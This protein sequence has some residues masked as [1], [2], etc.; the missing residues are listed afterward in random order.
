M[1]LLLGAPTALGRDSSS[2]AKKYYPYPFSLELDVD[3]HRVGALYQEIIDLISDGEKIPDSAFDAASYEFQAS[4]DEWGRGYKPAP[5]KLRADGRG[6]DEDE[7]PVAA[8]KSKKIADREIM[9]SAGSTFLVRLNWSPSETAADAF[10]RIDRMATRANAVKALHNLAKQGEAPPL[11][12][13]THLK[14]SDEL[15]HFDRFLS[16]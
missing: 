4:W 12:R 16:V 9:D 15:S 13:K 1:L 7:E 11:S 14:S 6:A 8:R 2:W 3:V 10:V 5:Y